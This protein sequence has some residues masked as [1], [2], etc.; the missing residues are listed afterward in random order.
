MSKARIRDSR[1][2]FAQQNVGS[3][4]ILPNR[5]PTP[6]LFPQIVSGISGQPGVYDQILVGHPK[7]AKHMGDFRTT[8]GAASY[9]WQP[10]DDETSEEA[11]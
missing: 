7:V 2:R 9:W 5:E 11:A 3:P 10:V 1:G 4:W 6:E 8:L